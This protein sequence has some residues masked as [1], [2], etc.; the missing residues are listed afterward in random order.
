MM[1]I[2]TVRAGDT[3]T[4]IA[5]AKGVSVDILQKV[6]MLTNPENLV[7]GQDILIL[8]PAVT[9]IVTEGETLSAIAQTYNTTVNN[10]LRNNPETNTDNLIPGTLLVISYADVNP[11]RDMALNGYTYPQIP[12][13]NL[14]RILPYL[15]FLTIFTYGFTNNGDLIAPEDDELI[16]LAQSYGVAPVMLIST[17]TSD[18]T[19]SNQLAATL[20]DS[21]E[22]QERLINNIIATMEAKGY[23]ALDI[24]FEFL[25][26]ENRE[27][28]IA[29]VAQLTQRLNERGWY[30][31][32]ALAPKT[33]ATQ[34]GL[35]YESHDYYGLG[36]AANFALL[37]TYEWGYTY[38]HIGYQYK[39]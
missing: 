3:L 23:R 38:G 26:V 14:K 32:V 17:L 31:L 6:N 1:E 36:R 11:T 4:S 15:T 29:F 34:P 21:P 2:Y 20:L 16:A 12:V 33:S 5:E 10:I 28:Y 37:M 30:T 13:E 19:F 9:H 22:L 8:R 24:D 7:A 18:G 35:L 27:S 39:L 25:P